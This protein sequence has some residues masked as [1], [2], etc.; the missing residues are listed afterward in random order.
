[1][2]PGK[3]VCVPLR[4]AAG[5]RWARARRS[6]CAALRGAGVRRATRSLA[7]MLAF[8]VTGVELLFILSEAAD[9]QD[10]IGR[11]RVHFDAVRAWR[12]TRDRSWCIHR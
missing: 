10:D 11:Q 1:M 12:N 4:V 7:G 8:L 2:L 9:N 3:S 6:A 5:G